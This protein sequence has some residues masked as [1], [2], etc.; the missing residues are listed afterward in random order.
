M[1]SMA[2]DY[3]V[4]MVDDDPDYLEMVEMM[5]GEVSKLDIETYTRPNEALES[6]ENSSTEVVLTDYEMP[7]MDGLEFMEKVYNIDSNIPVILYTSKGSEEIASKAI[8]RGVHDYMMKDTGMDHFEMLS[9]RLE[10]AAREYRDNEKIREL[11][12]LGDTLLDSSDPVIVW[13][14][15]NRLVFANNAVKQLVREDLDGE[16]GNPLDEL[17]EMSW[18]NE[19]LDKRDFVDHEVEIPTENGSKEANIVVS[20]LDD[21]DS[22][23]RYGLGI[24]HLLD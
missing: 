17:E 12:P 24:L 16:T 6:L 11:E 19:Y 14:N 2:D 3:G 13:N 10:N 9:N 18:F 1:V 4:V 22:V 5:I 7:T 21:G 23:S 20:S 15:D 8:S